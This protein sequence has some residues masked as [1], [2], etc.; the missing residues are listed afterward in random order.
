MIGT[1]YIMS[2]LR[3]EFVKVVMVMTPYAAALHPM[4]SMLLVIRHKI[5]ILIIRLEHRDGFSQLLLISLE[6]NGLRI[7]IMYFLVIV[8]ELLDY[9]T[10]QLILL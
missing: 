5:F 2:Q 10:Y 6:P 7:L 4:D 9:S 1:K 3:L 8:V